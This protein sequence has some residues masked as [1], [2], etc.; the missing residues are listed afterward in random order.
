MLK[1]SVKQPFYISIFGG[2]LVWL[3]IFLIT[4][5]SVV[6]TPSFETISFILSSYVFLIFGYRISSL[7]KP[8]KVSV[9]SSKKIFFITLVIFG[10][11]LLRY[12]DIF[13][14]REF[15]FSNTI[16]QNRVLAG[17]GAHH[18][19]FI[20]ASVFKTL[21][22]VPLLLILISK[23]KNKIVLFLAVIL[24]FMPFPEAILRGTRSTFFLSF[25]FLILILI[26]TKSVHLSKKNILFVVLGSILLFVIA[27]N[28]LLKRE[29]PKNDNPYKY[30]VEKAIYN[31]F[32]KPKKSV[33]D[34]MSN[35]SISNNK[36]KIVLSSLQIG[37]Y[38]SHG[39]FEFDYLIKHYKKH[40]LKKQYGKYTFFVIPKF[41]NQIKLTNYNLH[42]IYISSPRGYT[43]ITFFGGLYLDF[44]WF[45]LFPVF[46]LGMLQKFLSLRIQQKQFHYAPLFVFFL[47]TNFFMLTFNFFRGTGTYTLISCVIFALILSIPFKKA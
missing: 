8:L 2:L 21:Y 19:I 47:F 9:Y 7:K 11:F 45:A 38:F 12:I 33:I 36:K 43:F 10:C 20:I 22:F 35:D 18:L 27:T 42:D 44:G 6:N 14:F 31:D 39:L 3:F 28:I 24:F 23:N 46:L 17:N 37:Q 30:L 34:F 41:T 25:V 1:N 5:A 26:Y 16:Y 15:R 4:P 13:Y 29:G 32:Y 40:A